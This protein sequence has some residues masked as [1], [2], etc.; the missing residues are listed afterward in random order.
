MAFV[1]YYVNI[2]SNTN[3]MQQEP[4]SFEIFELLVYTYCQKVKG[5]NITNLFILINLSWKMYLL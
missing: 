4:H 3:A 1:L 2:Y 5:I